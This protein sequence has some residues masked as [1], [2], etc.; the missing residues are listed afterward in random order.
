[1]AWWPGGGPRE[2]VPPQRR[3][4]M[5]APKA[6]SVLRGRHMPE[7]CVHTKLRRDAQMRQKKVWEIFPSQFRLRAFGDASMELE[8]E[9]FDSEVIA[10]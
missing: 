6:P 7:S 3:E 8:I 1:M 4:K 2:H 10:G 9:L 5:G